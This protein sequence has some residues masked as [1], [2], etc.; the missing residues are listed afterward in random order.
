MSKHFELRVVGDYDFSTISSTLQKSIRRGEEKQAVYAAYLLHQSGYGEYCFRR[1][2]QIQSEDIGLT[3]PD[4]PLV[5]NALYQGWLSFHRH[6]KETTL[7]KFFPL[8]QAVL[9]LCRAKKNREID[10][11]INLIDHEFKQGKRLEIPDYCIDP[12]VQGSPSGKFGTKDGREL[13]RWQRWFTESSVVN[14]GIG[15][16][17]WH[18]EFKQAMYQKAK[19]LDDSVKK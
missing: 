11:L 18:E 1:L 7:N 8:A 10:S 4:A 15:I 19:E 14:N 16:D 6:S 5:V 9:F 13:E 3:Q 12:H 17:P 2:I